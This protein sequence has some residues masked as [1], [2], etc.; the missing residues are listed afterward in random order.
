MDSVY[1]HESPFETIIHVSEDM[2]D[3]SEIKANTCF[4]SVRVCLT[5]HLN[6][7]MFTDKSKYT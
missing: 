2:I 3:S 5:K 1:H 6:I 7:W 4:F